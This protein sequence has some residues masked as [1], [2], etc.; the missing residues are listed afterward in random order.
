MYPGA[1]CPERERLLCK[2]TRIVKVH[3]DTVS[4][5]AAVATGYPRRPGQS[6]EF[7][8]LA[9]EVRA[10]WAEAKGAWSEYRQHVEEHGC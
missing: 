3:T 10:S 1:I 8:R 4:Q 5:M 6:G 7:A 2:A 9:D